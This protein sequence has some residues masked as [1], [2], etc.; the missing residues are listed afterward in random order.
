MWWNSYKRLSLQG[1]HVSGIGSCMSPN[2]TPSLMHVNVARRLKLFHRVGTTAVSPWVQSN[3][4]LITETASSFPTAL[5]PTPAVDR[6][7]RYLVSKE[8]GRTADPPLVRP[9]A[10]PCYKLRREAWFSMARM[11][12]TLHYCSR[13]KPYP[14]LE[15]YSDHEG[16]RINNY[17]ACAGASKSA[18]IS[19]LRTNR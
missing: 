9:L 14:S 3:I 18:F 15:G 19:T 6:S 4:F 17:V 1:E 13:C 10:S 16:S 2:R 7:I 11:V 12:W 8:W 5:L